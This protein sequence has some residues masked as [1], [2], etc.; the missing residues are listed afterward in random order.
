MALPS[1]PLAPIQPA[2]AVAARPRIRCCVNVGDETALDME[3]VC[4]CRSPALRSILGADWRVFTIADREVL[5]RWGVPVIATQ[6]GAFKRCVCWLDGGTT[7]GG[8]PRLGVHIIDFPKDA[9]GFV[10]FEQRGAG[11]IE[12]QPRN[13]WDVLFGRIVITESG[14]GFR[15]KGWEPPGFVVRGSTITMKPASED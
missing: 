3:Q 15:P 13:L 1:T 9:P 7:V 14:G 6:N 2:D 8:H 11:F 12:P 10:E 5:K 4:S